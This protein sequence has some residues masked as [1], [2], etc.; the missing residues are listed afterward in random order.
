MVLF[1]L[2]YLTLYSFLHVYLYRKVSPLLGRYLRPAFGVFS[3]YMILSPFLWRY[4]DKEGLHTASYYVALS[5]LLWMGFVV[6][7]CLTGLTVDLVSKLKPLPAERRV[8]LTLVLSAVLSAYSHL[9]TY[10][11]QVYRFVINTPKLPEGEEIKIPAY[12]GPPPRTRDGRGQDRHG[13]RGLRKGK[14]RYGR[15]DR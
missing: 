12:I 13:P 8:S 15:C 14:A 2:L 9:E 10:Y 7:F 6:Y 11:L 4:L 3:L 5:G 1:L